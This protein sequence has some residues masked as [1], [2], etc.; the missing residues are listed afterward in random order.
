MVAI[1]KDTPAYTALAFFQQVIK[2]ESHKLETRF[3]AAK[4]ILQTPG[5]AAWELNSDSDSVRNDIGKSD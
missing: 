2:D 1:P 3:E 5:I 4:L